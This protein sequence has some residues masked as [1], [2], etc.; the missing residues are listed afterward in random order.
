MA[1]ALTLFTLSL[2]I[3]NKI[4]PPVNHP[5]ANS[6]RR[7][8][9]GTSIKPGPIRRLLIGRWPLISRCRQP[10]KPQSNLAGVGTGLFRYNWN[11][12]DG[13]NSI[14]RTGRNRNYLI[15]IRQS[16]S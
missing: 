7:K 2:F 1:K 15:P 3:Q 12:R 6:Q 10:H 13:V 16:I 14:S 9:H 4:K 8:T 11:N 5:G